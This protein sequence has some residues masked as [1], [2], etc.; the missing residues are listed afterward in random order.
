MVM[1]KDTMKYKIIASN[2]VIKLLFEN[3]F[4]FIGISM[5]DY[6]YIDMYEKSYTDFSLFKNE[7]ELTFSELKEI[8]S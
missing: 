1:K 2:E 7:D 3:N 6:I 5:N 8:I 4:K